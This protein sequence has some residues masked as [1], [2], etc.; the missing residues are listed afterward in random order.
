MSNEARKASHNLDAERHRIHRSEMSELDSA[1]RRQSEAERRRYLRQNTSY[2]MNMFTQLEQARETQE[3]TRDESIRQTPI[4]GY[5]PRFVPNSKDLEGYEQNPYRAMLLLLESSGYGRD[6]V[7]IPSLSEE[8]RLGSEEEW[9][10]DTVP[11]SCQDI[12]KLLKSYAVADDVKDKC[13]K[14]YLNRMNWKNSITYCACC[15]IYEICDADYI[16]I[17]HNINDEICQLLQMTDNDIN[18][19]YYRS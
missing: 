14:K 16:P 11:D 15:G 10:D 1:A 13:M 18:N 5:D 19:N 7:Y 2:E 3:E 17:W 6:E 8:P 12:W 4:Q 9:T